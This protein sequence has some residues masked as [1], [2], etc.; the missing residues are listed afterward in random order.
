MSWLKSLAF[1]LSVA[2]EGYL[3][4]CFFP[5]FFSSMLRNNWCQAMNGFTGLIWL[6]PMCACGQII[7]QNRLV[8]PD[9]TSSVVNFCPSPGRDPENDFSMGRGSEWN[10]LMH[11]RL[12]SHNA[13]NTCLRYFC[14]SGVRRFL[15]SFLFK[16]SERI[17]DQGLLLGL[18]INWDLMR[19]WLY[20]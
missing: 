10:C 18:K 9:T 16:L 1:T 12:I 2:Y 7:S 13:V 8:R 19:K 15:L 11:L 6:N 4:V 17:Y 3:S 5:I 20:S 14:N